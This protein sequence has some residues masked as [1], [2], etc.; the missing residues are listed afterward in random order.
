MQ[1]ARSRGMAGPSL[2]RGETFGTLGLLRSLIALSSSTALIK[3]RKNVL[4][5]FEDY[6]AG[7]GSQTEYFNALNSAKKANV[8]LYAVDVR[9]MTAGSTAGRS[10]PL[11]SL[12]HETGGLIGEISRNFVACPSTGPTS[13]IGPYV[14]FARLLRLPEPRVDHKL[15]IMPK[16]WCRI[17]KF[18]TRLLSAGRLSLSCS[19]KV[20]LVH[21]RYCGGNRRGSGREAEALE[22]L[23]YRLGRMD[24]G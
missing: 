20:R 22:N 7:P 17:G 1:T 5:S 14:N 18:H 2:G 19:R 23:S 4:L 9:D 3:G 13:D 6:V 12:A 10:A 16:R 21:V 15:D 11:S 24:C 8:S